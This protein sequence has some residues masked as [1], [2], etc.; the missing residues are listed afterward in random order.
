M[1]E[2]KSLFFSSLPLSPSF[3]QIAHLENLLKVYSDEI[4][5][6]QERE[7]SLEELEKEDSCY[8]QEHKLKRRVGLTGPCSVHGHVHS[9]GT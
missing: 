2:C 1:C 5:R 8:I 3:S 4:K 6:L 7:L 9:S